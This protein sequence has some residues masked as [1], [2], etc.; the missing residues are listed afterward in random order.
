M[1]S[2]ALLLLPEVHA[3]GESVEVNAQLFQPSTTG[4]WFGLQDAEMG[5]D[6]ELGWR[7]TFS[8]SDS[9]LQYTSFHGD[10]VTLVGGV[11][12]VDLG[13][14]YRMGRFQAGLN[15]PL[16][17]ASS[18]VND[19]GLGI[20]QV[21]FDAKVQLSGEG[22][23]NQA[24]VH[25]KVLL[26]NGAGATP[27][28]GGPFG[29][30]LGFVGARGFGE[31]TLSGQAGAIFT[32]SSATL[33]GAR[34]GSRLNL[35]VGAARVE[36]DSLPIITEL[37][38]QPQ[39]G[40]FGQSN[41]EL[42]LGSQL[43]I[44]ALESYLV[45]P[46]VVVG[47]GDAPGTPKYRVMAQF[48]REV[49]PIRDADGDGIMGADDACPDVAE[50]MDNHE[51]TDGCPDPTRVTVTIKDS[52]GFDA[53][54]ISWFSGE[55][56]GSSGG[57][58][59]M[60]AGE[61]TFTV[62]GNEFQREIPGGAEAEVVIITPA[63]RGRLTVTAV[64]ADGNAVEGALWSA[65]GPVD[66]TD[67]PAGEE[68]MVRPGSYQLRASAPGF[69]P[70]TGEVEVSLTGEATLT[71]TMDP[72]RVAVTAERIEIEGSVFYETGNAIIKP[73]SFPLLD[74][75]AELLNDHPELTL[76]RIEG[77]TDSRGR[78]SANLT[79]SQARA[80]SVL[81][82]LVRGGVSAE[83][84]TAVGY[85]EDRP[86]ESGNNAAA[87]EKNRRVDFFVVERADD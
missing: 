7:T 11:S 51:D 34:W 52:D 33:E 82:Y 77:H 12:Q 5:V 73:E 36:G 49:E 20:G 17:F 56:S 18:E 64:D 65:T 16:Q 53:P 60:H 57:L 87:W 67:Q 48:R 55:L 58:A 75:I 28:L 24:A 10:E 83:R 19:A 70:A 72:A 3:V 79:L 23:D 62:L 84:L 80:D 71:L 9:P 78:A 13:A 40:A 21:R 8:Y 54:D 15:A 4:V 86:L 30:E 27:G 68:V 47:L 43:E 2:L 22:G 31:W 66:A 69:R 81:E 38:I 61:A 63:P 25:A 37:S 44:G 74:E 85:G 59:L 39:V 42:L 41:V 6:G 50:D 35:G 76:V 26:P 46:A 1:F 45:R 14:T 32:P 29:A